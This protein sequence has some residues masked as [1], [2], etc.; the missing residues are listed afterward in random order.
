MLNSH[1]RSKY[2]IP[3]KSKNSLDAKT[4]AKRCILQAKFVHTA[5]MSE[6]CWLS[7]AHS[8]THTAHESSHCE[9]L[10]YYAV[11]VSHD[12]E[13]RTVCFASLIPLT[14]ANLKVSLIS[15]IFKICKS[16]DCMVKDPILLSSIHF[17]Y[18]HAGTVN[19]SLNH[20]LHAVCLYSP[21]D[22]V[23]VTFLGADIFQVR[24]SGDVKFS[25]KM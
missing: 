9:G 12:S 21:H 17:S 1:G 7:S 24:K 15:F 16:G 6:M 11:R 22:Q 3:V 23:V 18:A 25:T 8:D 20:V 10:V 2:D 4:N 19:L 5:L 13:L 14:N